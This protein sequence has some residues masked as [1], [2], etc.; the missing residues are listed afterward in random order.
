VTQFVTR[1]YGVSWV[2]RDRSTR[3]RMQHRAFGCFRRLVPGLPERGVCSDGVS[4]ATR[5]H[6]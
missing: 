4:V 1:H 6:T 2:P 5:Y 3:K